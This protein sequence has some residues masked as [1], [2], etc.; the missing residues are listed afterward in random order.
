MRTENQIREAEQ[1]FYDLVWYDRKLQREEIP[2][3]A[4]EAI[5]K[6]E[7]KY[8]AS[9][10][11]PHSDFEWGMINGKLSALRWI[12]GQEWDSLDS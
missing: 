11:G 2:Q 4:K 7:A 12:L 9:E 1:K 3:L 5:L 8:S 6:I 10:L